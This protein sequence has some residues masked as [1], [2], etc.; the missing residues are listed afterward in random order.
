[1]LLHPDAR[2]NKQAMPLHAWYIV[3]GLGGEGGGQRRL[4][5]LLQ[6]WLLLNNH[7]TNLILSAY[8][9]F[10]LQTYLLHESVSTLQYV[11]RA[12]ATRRFVWSMHRVLVAAKEANSLKRRYLLLPPAPKYF[13]ALPVLRI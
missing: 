7:N 8:I 12:G 4:S 5:A 6:T 13:K 1:M 10:S 2:D 9:T 3:C 11:P